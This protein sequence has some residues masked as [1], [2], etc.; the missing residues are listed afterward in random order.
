MAVYEW[1]CIPYSRIIDTWYGRDKTTIG[2]WLPF[3]L[4]H[5]EGTCQDFVNEMIAVGRLHIFR[6]GKRDI[7]NGKMVFLMEQ[8]NSLDEES[9]ENI[10]CLSKDVQYIEEHFTD[11]NKLYANGVIPFS[12]LMEHAKPHTTQEIDDRECVDKY[13]D[14]AMEELPNQSCRECYDYL[15]KKHKNKMLVVGIL[16]AMAECTQRFQIKEIAFETYRGEGASRQA[17]DSQYRTNIKNFHKQYRLDKYKT[18]DKS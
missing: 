10:F 2:P 5:Y 14:E 15:M 7:Y 8:L 13:I 11:W 1:D 18:F 12:E 9:E 3:F 17:Y 16:S 6:K 4:F